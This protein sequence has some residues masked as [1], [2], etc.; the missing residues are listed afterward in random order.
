MIGGNHAIIDAG[1]LAVEIDQFKSGY[2][3]LDE[4]LDTYYTEMIP[5]CKVAVETSHDAAIIIHTKP[6]ELVKMYQQLHASRA[7]ALSK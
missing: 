5:R 6:D 2:K 3:T 7:K 4:A 1:K